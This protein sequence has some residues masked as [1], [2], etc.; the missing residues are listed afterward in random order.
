MTRPSA[1]PV[2]LFSF[3]SITV[4]A[5]TCVFANGG[6][7]VR[8]Y[9]LKKG[10][11]SMKVTNWG[12]RITS[13]VLPDKNGKL[14]DVVLGF[15]SAN[16]YMTNKDYFGSVVGRVANRIAKARFTLNGTRYK[17]IPNEGHNTLHGGPRGFSDV[18]WTVSRYQKD[19][20]APG[21]VFKYLSKDGE[22]G[23][24]GDLRVTVSYSLRRDNTLRVSMRAKAI[25]KATPVN[26]AQHTYWNLG[27]HCS[28]SILSEDLQIFAS[29]ITPVDSH[30]IPTGMIA[31]V[32]GTPYD[33]RQPKKIG[34]QIAALPKG[35]DINYVLDSSR[36]SLQR[37]AVVHDR[38]S[39]RVMELSTNQPGVQL[40]TG[41]MLRDVKGK[42]GC[43]YGAHAAL[44]LETQKYP[45]SVNRP[46]FPS[47]IVSPGETYNHLMLF[48]FSIKA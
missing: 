43:E 28:G 42:G 23:F 38:R 39:G 16:E 31:S 26:L 41:N 40:Y 11:M 48:R 22:E 27:G 4:F 12:A 9:E 37:A 18:A 15:D 8:V 34:S 32:V 17:L 5:S 10:N 7:G 24:P 2:L 20:R 13:I 14:D 35:F 29:N 33:F 44:C 30:L 36:K 19:G 25:D 47:E 1:L 45:D 46:N 3:F 6:D 21:I